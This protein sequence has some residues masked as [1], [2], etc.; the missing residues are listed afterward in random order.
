[1]VTRRAFLRIAVAA[2]LAVPASGCFQKR[3]PPARADIAAIS[4]LH[5]GDPRSML[6]DHRGREM[7]VSV[8]ADAA[9][10]RG[11]HTLVLDG[12]V[13][14]LALA[15]ETSAFESARSLFALLDRVRGLERVVLVIGNHDH[16]LFEDI[17]DPVP[18]KIGRE[19]DADTRF[20]RE[21]APV[22]PRLRITV[23]YP[24]WTHALGRGGAVHF[25]HGHYFDRLVTP[26]F[27]G[28]GSVQ[29]IEERNQE[30]WAFLN[31]GGL[32]SNIRSLYRAAYHFGHHLGA[33]FG[34]GDVHEEE[35]AEM[36]RREQDRV[37]QYLGTH[38]AEQDVVAVVAGHTHSKGGRVAT[39]IDAEGRQVPVFDTGAFV[40]GHHGKKSRPHV[41]Y[42]DAKSGAMWLEKVDVPDEVFDATYERAFDTTP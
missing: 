6:H 40:V 26:S 29:E 19:Y 13:L 35:L 10:Q 2:L 18:E 21:V 37:V 4:D 36:T 24:G 3:A 31:A 14:E 22:A 17:P 15:S 7:L 28:A 9:A 16:R 23:V 34:A 27:D 38:L 8:I 39:V 5:L 42:L 11:V 12:D 41:F 20:H 1:M 32:D 30:W 33:W 25:T